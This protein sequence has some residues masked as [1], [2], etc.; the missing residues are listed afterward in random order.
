MQKGKKIDKKI[1]KI[2]HGH[3]TDVKILEIKCSSNCP[4]KR[5]EIQK[6]KIWAYIFANAYVFPNKDKNKNKNHLFLLNQRISE[7]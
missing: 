7:H 4:E 3:L 5:S 2:Q 1:R 6:V